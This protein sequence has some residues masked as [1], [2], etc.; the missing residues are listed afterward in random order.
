MPI[1]TMKNVKSK[2]IEDMTLTY[3][4]MKAMVDSG[5]W[6]REFSAPAQIGGTSMDSGKLP[7]GFEDKM[8]EMKKIHPLGR[9]ADHLI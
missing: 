2:K 4:E 9:G 5:D 8:R 6:E 1:Y 7:E 3:D